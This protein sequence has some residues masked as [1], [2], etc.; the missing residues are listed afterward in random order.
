MKLHAAQSLYF[1]S[2]NLELA[3]V[4]TESSI[5]LIPI[6]V[7]SICRSLLCD[8]ND[9]SVLDALSYPS[10]EPV[11]RLSYSTRGPTGAVEKSFQ[12]FM[13]IEIRPF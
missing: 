6:L 8:I 2:S 11:L 4:Q 13:A 12:S 5:I 3:C 7:Y 9:F 1:L 10:R